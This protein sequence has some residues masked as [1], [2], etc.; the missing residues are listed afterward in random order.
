MPALAGGFSSFH[1]KPHPLSLQHKMKQRGSQVQARMGRRKVWLASVANSIFPGIAAGFA[2]VFLNRPRPAFVD[3]YWL[4]YCSVALLSAIGMWYI[5]YFH[6]APES[7]KKEYLAMYA[8]TKQV[9][10]ERG[11]NP[12]PNLFHIGIHFLFVVNFCLAFALRVRG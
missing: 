1:L 3:N 10:P 12:R 7:Q 9:L 6:G 4:I 2:L 11:N 5:P 8:G